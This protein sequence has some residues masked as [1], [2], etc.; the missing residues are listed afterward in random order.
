MKPTTI[1][2]LVK[3]SVLNG[4]YLKKLAMK[5]HSKIKKKSRAITIAIFEEN[6]KKGLNLL[7][8][9][10]AWL[11]IHLL[12]KFILHNG[13][14]LNRLGTSFNVR[15]IHKYYNKQIKKKKLEKVLMVSHLQY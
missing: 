4:K 7:M 9:S 8:L 13:K 3:I 2:N 10:K 15:K 1:E 12:V 5:V 6:L 14:L 11:D